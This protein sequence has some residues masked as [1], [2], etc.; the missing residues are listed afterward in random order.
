MKA[1]TKTHRLI[2]YNR[3]SG[4]WRIVQH[5]SDG[6][7]TRLPGAYRTRNEAGAA[8]GPAA[9]GLATEITNRPGLNP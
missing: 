9:A 6:S 4:R 5:Y 7:F 3:K 2:A 1:R 8:R